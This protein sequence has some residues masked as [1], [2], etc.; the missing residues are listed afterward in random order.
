M[1]SGG[2][3]RK[4][5]YESRH[6]LVIG[7]GIVGLAMGFRL[8]QTY[9]NA[10]V[11]VLEKENAVGPYQSGHNSG[12]LHFGMYQKPGSLKARLADT[13]IRQMIVFCTASHTRSAESSSLPRIKMS[14][15]ATP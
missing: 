11:A 9:P 3:S 13:E 2:V 5:K 15:H 1:T 4:Y 7:G 12:V 8:V 6:V 14:R 10:A